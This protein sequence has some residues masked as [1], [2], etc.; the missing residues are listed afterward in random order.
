MPTIVQLYTYSIR[1]LVTWSSRLIEKT[2]IQWLELLIAFVENVDSI[3]QKFF[4]WSSVWMPLYFDIFVHLFFWRWG[5]DTLRSKGRCG[6][7]TRTLQWPWRQRRNFLELQFQKCLVQKNTRLY[8]KKDSAVVFLHNTIV[9][10]TLQRPSLIIIF[11]YKKTRITLENQPCLS[12]KCIITFFF[13][14]LKNE[15][16]FFVIFSKP[17][18]YSKRFPSQYHILCLVFKFFKLKNVVWLVTRFCLA[19]LFRL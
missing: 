2:Q 9:N 4:S 5:V 12:F 13:K 10:Q 1:G 11:V 3:W 14:G 15:N 16:S 6:G 18:R 7:F 19:L 17:G 8:K